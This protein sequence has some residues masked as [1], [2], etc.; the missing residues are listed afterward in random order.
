MASWR[1][2][3]AGRTFRTASAVLLAG[4]LFAAAPSASRAAEAAAGPSAS[5]EISLPEA[6]RNLEA[7][8]PGGV[9][10]THVSAKGAKLS[11]SGLAETTGQITV[12]LRA[13]GRDAALRNP[14]LIQVQKDRGTGLLK[15]DMEADATCLP[16]SGGGQPGF[17][18]ATAMR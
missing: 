18:K 16:P 7:S 3:P 13:L 10:L 5:V 12:Y 9:R 11:F 14:A 6:R 1:N 2:V 8:T 17:C 15:F 4:A